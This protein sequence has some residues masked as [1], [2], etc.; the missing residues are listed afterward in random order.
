MYSAET[1]VQCSKKN[2]EKIIYQ[3]S[4][5]GTASLYDFYFPFEG[6]IDLT[7]LIYLVYRNSNFSLFSSPNKVKLR[8]I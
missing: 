3:V 5:H 7:Y 8:M 2:S 1:T 4:F 6:R